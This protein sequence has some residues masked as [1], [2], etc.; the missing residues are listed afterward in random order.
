MDRTYERNLPVS[1]LTV[2]RVS[3][4][5]A[6]LSPFVVNLSLINK[7]DKFAIIIFYLRFSLSTT[8]HRKWKLIKRS[9]TFISK[10]SQVKFPLSAF[11]IS[12]SAADPFCVV[13][14]LLFLAQ[15]LCLLCLGLGSV[16]SL[17][18]C[19]VKLQTFPVYCFLWNQH[20]VL[21]LQDLVNFPILPFTPFRAHLHSCSA[22]PL[23]VS[24][25]VTLHFTLKRWKL[26]CFFFAS[27]FRHS[28][29][30]WYLR[31]WTV[32]SWIRQCLKF[33]AR[34]KA[35]H[36]LKN[37]VF[38]TW[39]YVPAVKAIE[40][41]WVHIKQLCPSYDQREIIGSWSGIMATND[42]VITVRD[43]KSKS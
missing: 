29:N 28:P 32:H 26:L 25:P 27:R 33:G 23:W 36:T 1:S 40:D 10:D 12:V 2:S 8:Y 17:L 16:T 39:L 30:C 6:L 7:F 37:K 38:I 22:L 4:K 41:F 14:S 9:I 13:A 20:A 35:L 34:E 5:C 15:I 31:E 18:F 21:W 43:Y 11:H 3:C 19:S 42:H 24:F